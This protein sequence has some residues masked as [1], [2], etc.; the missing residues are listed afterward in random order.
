MCVCCLCLSVS[1]VCAVLFVYLISLYICIYTY[2]M[3]VSLQVAQEASIVSLVSW[4][5][6][7]RKKGGGKKKRRTT[8]APF[9]NS[10]FDMHSVETAFSIKYD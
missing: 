10:I 5:D 9:T 4:V 1:C 2:I 8:T 7:G 3:Y 6:N